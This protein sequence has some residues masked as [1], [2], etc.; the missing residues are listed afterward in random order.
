[1]TN[2]LSRPVTLMFLLVLALPAAVLAQTKDTADVHGEVLDASGQPAVGYPMKIMTPLS[3]EVIIKSTEHDGTFGVEGLPPGNYELRVF[4]PGGSTDTP[5][6]SKQV[7]LAAGQAEKIEIRVGSHKPAAA[8]IGTT[9]VNW[10]F[11]QRAGLVLA[12]GLIAF[13]VLRA[14]RRSRANG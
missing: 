3:G 4:E 7:T 12:A 6:A 9:G 8:T 1:M 11:V 10:T 13:I 5:I 2:S 14:Q